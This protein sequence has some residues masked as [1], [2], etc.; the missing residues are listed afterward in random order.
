MAISAHWGA[1][2]GDGH[3]CACGAHLD[4]DEHSWDY[5]LADAVLPL[6]HAERDKARAEVV[7]EFAQW[8]ATNRAYNGSDHER[9]QSLYNECLNAVLPTW[10]RE[11]TEAGRDD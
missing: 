10:A 4:H 5:H 3:A 6:I 8:V 1:A 9:G 2:G 7:E 11:F